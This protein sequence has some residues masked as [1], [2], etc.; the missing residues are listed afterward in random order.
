MSDW[1][2]KTAFEIREAVAQ[3]DVSAREVTTSF[4]DRIEAVDGAV[5]AYTQLWN[6]DALAQADAV[7]AKVKAGEA[8]GALAGVP[9]SLKELICTTSGETTCSSRILN[10]FQSPYNAT[11]TKKLLAADD[12]EQIFRGI[13]EEDAKF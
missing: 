13:E 1:F 6:D 8:L 2:N 5:G 12:L 7:D 3:G 11:V 4:L 10:G 9:I